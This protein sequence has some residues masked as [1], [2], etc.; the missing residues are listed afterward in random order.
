MLRN[1]EHLTP[2]NKDDLSIIYGIMYKN[3]RASEYFFLAKP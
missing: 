3:K 2:T 1:T